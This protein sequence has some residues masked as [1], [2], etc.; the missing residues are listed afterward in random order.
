MVP[1]DKNSVL[2]NECE[3]DKFQTVFLEYQ[4][5]DLLLICHKR[6]VSF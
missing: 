3:C 6:K 2:W 1:D 5:L 4:T